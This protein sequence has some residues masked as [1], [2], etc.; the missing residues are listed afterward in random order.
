M[1]GGDV[2]TNAYVF[3]GDWVDR[4]A[5]QLE[6][7]LAQDGAH[8]KMAITSQ[9]PAFGFTPRQKEYSCHNWTG[10]LRSR[11]RGSRF[12]SP[13]FGRLTFSYYTEGCM[14]GWAWG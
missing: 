14:E 4:G 8:K 9:C 5:H 2:E 11:S 12:T 10:S 7:R 6:V 1:L 13:L 3:N